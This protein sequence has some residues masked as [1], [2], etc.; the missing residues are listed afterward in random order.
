[1]SSIAPH[2]HPDGNTCHSLPRLDTEE[3][4]MDRETFMA[5]VEE[6]WT[7][8]RTFRSHSHLA[9]SPKRPALDQ[10]HKIR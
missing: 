8:P 2:G 7:P 1:M 5:L 3:H 4:G 10:R 6:G 9:D